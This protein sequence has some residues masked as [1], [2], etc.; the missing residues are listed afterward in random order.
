MPIHDWNERYVRREMPWDSDEA[1]KNLVELVRERG[2]APGRALDVGSGTGTNAIWLAAQGFDVLGVDVSARAV[3]LANAKLGVAPARCRFEVA[4]FLAGEAP[5]GS[6]DLVF[7]RGCFHVFDDPDDRARFA[8]RVA[9]CLAPE[10]LWLSL[11]GSTEG[12]PRDHG[13]PR[14]SVRDIAS[15]IEPVLEIAELRAIQFDAELPTAARA[16]LCVSRR[17]EVPA[18]PS[19][20]QSGS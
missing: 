7:D 17:R 20:G 10:G 2:L 12:P 1:D 18:Q 8:A 16:W 5:I 9:G 6:F 4:D 3:E 14:R 19:T 15:A 11:M 13:P